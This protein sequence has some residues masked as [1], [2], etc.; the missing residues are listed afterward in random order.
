MPS[1]QDAPLKTYLDHLARGEL[2]YQFSPEAGRAVFYPRMLCP[3][4]GSEHGE[5]EPA[6]RRRGIGPRILER[7][8]ASFGLGHLVQHIE[9]VPSR[10]CHSVQPRDDQ[11]VARLDRSRLSSS[12][13]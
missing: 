6:M 2:A 7:T 8:K 5:H 1:S 10:P 11:H 3:F 12:V 9:Q 13:S 4:T